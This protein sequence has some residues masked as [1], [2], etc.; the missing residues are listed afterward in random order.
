MIRT[1]AISVAVALSLVIGGCERS[2]REEQEK[3]AS[4]QREAEKK[5]AEATRESTTKITAAQTEAAKTIEQATAAFTKTQ[6]DY[7]TSLANRLDILQK[8]IEKL[9]ARDKVA[10][11]KA[12]AAID[13]ALPDIRAKSKTLHT[14]M[15]Q[16]KG[17]TM[18]N[19]DGIKSQLD[20]DLDGLENAVNK[21]PPQAM[22]LN[23]SNSKTAK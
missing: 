17:A 5:A 16:L 21:A 10:T 19:W 9:E 8:K 13:A 20:T 2:G 11:G 15:A 4:A 6:Q 14:D 18:S 12:K 23:Q 22:Q 7:Q 3:A 1:T